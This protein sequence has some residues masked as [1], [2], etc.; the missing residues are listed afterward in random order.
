M[1]ASCVP[2]AKKSVTGVKQNQGD[3][4]FCD[5][6]GIV[7]HDYAPKG[8]TVAKEAKEYYQQVIKQ[9]CDTVWLKR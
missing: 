7:R 5:F 4:V 1:E 8:Q 3:A 9:L 2:E 6:H